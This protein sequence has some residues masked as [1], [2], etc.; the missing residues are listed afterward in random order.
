M[1]AMAMAPSSLAIWM[2]AMPTELEAAEM[3]T[4]SSLAMLAEVDESAPRREV[5]HPHRR[6]FGGCEL[7]RIGRDVGHGHDRFLAEHGIVI[8]GKAGDGGDLAADPGAID[9]GADGFDDA[10]GFIA[11]A[12]GQTRL[13][14]ILAASVEGFGAVE[15]NGLNADADFAGLGLARGLLFKLENLGTAEL[16]EAHNLGHGVLLVSLDGR[17]GPRV[18]GSTKMI[19]AVAIWRKGGEGSGLTLKYGSGFPCDSYMRIRASPGEGCTA[20]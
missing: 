4:K 16:M 3:M 17:V 18:Q 11:E 5:L 7:F 12:G 20:G 9:A 8:E 2:A 1:V 13:L 15:A 10:G 19:R 6:G 14:Q